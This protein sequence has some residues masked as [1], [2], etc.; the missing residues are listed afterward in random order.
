MVV[1]EP[2]DGDQRYRL[3]EPIREYAHEKLAESGAL[4]ETQALHARAVCAI[5]EEWYDEWDRGP[6]ADWLAPI[7]RDLANLR[8]ALRWCVEQA[9]DVPLG[10]RLVS[11]AT[12]VFLRLGFLNEGVG[13]CDRALAASALPPAVE[14][15]LR[16]G[17]SMLYSN[18]GNDKKCLDEALH[19]V[20]LYREAGDSRGLARALSQVASRYAFSG[21][22]DEAETTARE[23]LELAHETGDRRLIAD[24]LR[25]CAEAFANGG[26]DAVR[27]RYA[28]A[29]TLF[30]ALGRNDETARALTW[31][32]NWELQ[33]GGYAAAA[34]L[35][36]EAAAL[37]DSDAAAMFPLADIASTYLAIGDR[38]RA[39]LYARKTLAAASKEGHEVLSSLAMSY[40]AAVVVDDDAVKAARLMG[41]AETRLRSAA[42]TLH[43]PDTTTLARLRETLQAR[44][45]EA[46]LQRLFREGAAW[47]DDQAVSH[48]LA[49]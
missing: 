9:N 29:A 14:A 7:E 26:G 40:L 3:L 38:A 13:W 10:A 20:S 37:E 36:E 44:F 47:S 43:P 35:L 19:A 8:A 39:E 30:K 28:E 34:Q 22:F 4:A 21:R 17:M 41:N 27:E 25:R 33:T 42:W 12:I 6:S 31:W 11:A 1:L 15:R 2:S 49:A 45:A 18:L 48:A 32:G 23:S 5:A 46:E 16:Y 24:S